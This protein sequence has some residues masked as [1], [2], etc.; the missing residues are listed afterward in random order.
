MT[1]RLWRTKKGHSEEKE[2]VQTMVTK[3][4]GPESYGENMQQDAEKAESTEGR[5]AEVQ[6][7]SDELNQ[8]NKADTPDVSASSETVSTL[9]AITGECVT[10]ADVGVR[11]GTV[12]R[13]EDGTSE[14]HEAARSGNQLPS[15]T[16]TQEVFTSD[17][18]PQR[19]SLDLEDERCLTPEDEKQKLCVDHQE[20]DTQDTKYCHDD[21]D[22]DIVEGTEDHVHDIGDRNTEIADDTTKCD[23]GD[24]NTSTENG[25][26][27]GDETGHEDTRGDC[28]KWGQSSVVHQVTGR[29][30]TLSGQT[31]IVS[32]SSHTTLKHSITH[33]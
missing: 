31:D 29:Y 2:A 11:E 6:Q 14:L 18:D 9:P 32:R 4:S 22:E 15:E 13:H 25:T 20:N 12:V 10:T 8:F 19:N 1:A 5:F 23:H 26:E 27:D 3:T 28:S 17:L 30:P 16:G 7:D 33:L 24:Q 21:L